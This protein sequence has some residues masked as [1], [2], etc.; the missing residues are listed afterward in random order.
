M[1]T[2][3]DKLNTAIDACSFLMLTKME[4]E[5]NAKGRLAV[6]QASIDETLERIEHLKEQVL[7]ERKDRQ[8]KETK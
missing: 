5:V 1:R 2:T 7:Q 4:M 8:E 3:L 6:V